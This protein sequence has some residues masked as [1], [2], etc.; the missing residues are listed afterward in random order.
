MENVLNILTQFFSSVENS[1]AL[2]VPVTL[3]LKLM[4]MKIFLKNYYRT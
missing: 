3:V 4:V 1:V 2:L